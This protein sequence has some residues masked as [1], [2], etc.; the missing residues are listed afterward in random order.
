MSF[1]QRNRVR[2]VIALLLIVM[3]AMTLLFRYQLAPIA[4][5][6]IQT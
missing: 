2:A 1:A 3:S 6:L 4:Q 5:E